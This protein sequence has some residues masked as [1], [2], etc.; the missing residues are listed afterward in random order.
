MSTKQPPCKIP[1]EGGQRALE[2]R[3]IPS[4][5]FYFANVILSVYAQ[6]LDCHKLFVVNPSP[7]V[8]KP[9]RVYGEIFPRDQ[10]PGNDIR[11]GEESSAAAQ[12][13]ESLEDGRVKGTGSQDLRHVVSRQHTGN[14]RTSLAYLVKDL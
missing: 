2:S 6:P 14:P 4:H 9:T 5:P 7:D 10:T 13:P 1:N 3:I 8:T 11:K 12:L